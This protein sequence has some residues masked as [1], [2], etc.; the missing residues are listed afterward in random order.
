MENIWWRDKDFYLAKPNQV[1]FFFGK[2]LKLRNKL[3]HWFLGKMNP[4]ILKYTCKVILHV[5]KDGSCRLCGDYKP[6]NLQ[7]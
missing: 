7:T 4:N 6:L 2:K 1:V 5:K 3:M